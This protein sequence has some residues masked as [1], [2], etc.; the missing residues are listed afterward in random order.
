MIQFLG[1]DHAFVLLFIYILTK[2]IFL[3]IIFNGRRKVFMVKLKL[4]DAP[5]LFIFRK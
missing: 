3:K 1:G 4:F 5:V 2:G